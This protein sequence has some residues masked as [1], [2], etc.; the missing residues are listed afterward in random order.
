MLNHYDGSNSRRSSLGPGLERSFSM[1]DSVFSERQSHSHVSEIEIFDISLHNLPKLG[2]SSWD[3][4][5]R[6]SIGVGHQLQTTSWESRSYSW[7]KKRRFQ[8]AASESSKVT[9]NIYARD[10]RHSRRIGSFE[11]TV[12]ML[13]NCSGP[14]KRI[15]NLYGAQ[16]QKLEIEFKIVPSPKINKL[17]ISYIDLQDL[18]SINHDTF[19]LRVA[20]DDTVWQSTSKS[21][22]QGHSRWTDGHDYP[23]HDDSHASLEIFAT[24][25]LHKYKPIAVVQ[26]PVKEWLAAPNGVVCQTLESMGA[27]IQAEFKIAQISGTP[28]AG[29]HYAEDAG[30][31]IIEQTDCDVVLGANQ[32]D[33]LDISA[34]ILDIDRVP[35]FGKLSWDD[36]F[37]LE[38]TV[39]DNGVSQ[40]VVS[41]GLREK[42]S[43]MWDTTFTLKVSRTSQLVFRV[44]GY[45][46]KE[47]EE[48]PIGMAICRLDEILHQN[49]LIQRQLRTSAT[50]AHTD[51]IPT[52]SF[53]AMRSGA[54]SFAG[55]QGSFRQN[56]SAVVNKTANSIVQTNQIRNHDGDKQFIQ[57]AMSR[58]RAVTAGDAHL[59]PLLLKIGVFVLVAE[60]LA[61]VHPYARLAFSI[62][63]A[64]YE[65]IRQSV[66]CDIGVC[67]LMDTMYETYDLITTFEALGHL[68]K[69][70][71][72]VDA[73]VQQTIECAFFIRDYADKRDN[74]AQAIKNSI[75]N[76]EA[77]IREFQDTFLSLQNKFRLHLEVGTHLT[78]LKLHDELQ[79]YGAKADFRDMDYVVDAKCAAS[80]GI[81]Q[82]TDSVA[83]P[84]DDVISSIQ[85]WV[86]GESKEAERICVLY[87]PEEL[88]SAIAR[89]VGEEF[90]FASRLGSSYCFRNPRQPKDRNY[91]NLFTTIA[92][93]LADK[94]TRFKDNLWSIVKNDTSLRGTRVV[95]TQFEEFILAPSRDAIWTGPL[96]VI[97]DSLELGGDEASRKDILAVLA[98]KGVDL[99]RN[100]R[101][102]ITCRPEDDICKAFRGL[103]HVLRR[104]L[105][106]TSSTSI[107]A[108]KPVLLNALSSTSPSHAI[109]T[110][111]PPPPPNLEDRRNSVSSSS[112]SESSAS[113][114]TSFSHTRAVSPITSIESGFDEKDTPVQICPHARATPVV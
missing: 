36:R 70:K 22:K 88:C 99:P 15:V 29:I 90:R 112:S 76:I 45:D 77:Q 18:P 73:I 2:M 110:S 92:R 75:L 35:K 8:V 69:R 64:G 19:F 28:H 60:R 3:D 40:K 27:K 68:Q 65:V 23:F 84:P 87:G 32:I 89:V 104:Q 91:T 111:Q 107:G 78:V 48:I 25:Y 50:S 24:R 63:T 71:D 7:H 56:L 10:I 95:R 21:S 31:T 85:S 93:D 103:P 100:L 105:G 86:I 79:D 47:S 94:N 52:L 72:I 109:D 26:G 81:H 74:F 14:I 6:V 51:G 61:Q 42:K 17:C 39:D 41:Q 33:A 106:E 13:L 38:I 83:T 43:L 58:V 98:H 113:G 82:P 66:A 11:D 102:L 44:L 46:G 4:R 80:C 57:D 67:Q 53:R 54:E 101:F 34:V 12:G 16:D 114:L 96:L 9:F 37:F 49:S 62:L 97:I 59:S 20:V 55:S 1:N 5:F 30:N 108:E